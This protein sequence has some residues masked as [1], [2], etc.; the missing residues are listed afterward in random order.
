[1]Q[2]C[3]R[4]NRISVIIRDNVYWPHTIHVSLYTVRQIQKTSKFIDARRS[5]RYML[6][7]TINST[8]QLGQ[9]DR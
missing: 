5:L 9:N 2:T 8:V 3:A 7:P 6:Q 4:N 1:M